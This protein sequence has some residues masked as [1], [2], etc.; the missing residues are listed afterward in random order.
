V[1]AERERLEKQMVEKRKH[2]QG[3]R[4]KLENPNFVGKAPAEVVQQQRDLVAEL[5]NQIRIME[6]TLQEL[7]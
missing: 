2:L 3:A 4:A 7:Q 6:Q 5:E 1:A